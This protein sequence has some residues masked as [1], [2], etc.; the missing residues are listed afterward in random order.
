MKHRIEQAVRY[1][2]IEKIGYTIELGPE[3][4]LGRK[5]IMTEIAEEIGLGEDLITK[6]NRAIIYL[7]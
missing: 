2:P 7:C 6:P 3:S 1:K 4:Y 5:Q